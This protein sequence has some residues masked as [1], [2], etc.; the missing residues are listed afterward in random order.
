MTDEYEEFLLTI[1]ALEH[2]RTF[3]NKYYNKGCDKCLLADMCG[4]TGSTDIDS[5]SEL[6]S[7]GL[8][9]LTE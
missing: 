3:C 4:N 6:V 7:I 8:K 9:G 5:L 1:G 2:L